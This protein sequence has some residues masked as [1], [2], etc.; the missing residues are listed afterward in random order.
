MKPNYE[1]WTEFDW[2]RELR[3]DDERIELYMR[4]LDDFID[5]PGEDD[6]VL[7][8]MRSKP[9]LV[10]HETLWDNFSALNIWD[11][12]DPS[13]DERPQP[14]YDGTRPRGV[15]KLYTGVRSM[16]MQWCGLMPELDNPP[17]RESCLRLITIFGRIFIRL[18]D[19]CDMAAGEMP[20]LRIALVKRA[21][22]RINDL[23]GEMEGFS[24]P[25]AKRLASTQRG[26]LH[27]IRLELVK[28][29]ESMRAAG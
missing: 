16:A 9:G 28:E 13:D 5:L 14:E 4:E 1:N 24:E 20:A 18:A 17:S 15:A 3:R 29:L 19:V 7:G 27:A 2:E 8:R 26:Q 25:L 6:L 10:P 22:A 12:F 23:F 11:G 21:L